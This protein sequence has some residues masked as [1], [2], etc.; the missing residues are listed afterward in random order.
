MAE[1]LVMIRGTAFAVAVLHGSRYVAFGEAEV[2]GVP[3]CFAVLFAEEPCWVRV[4]VE[5]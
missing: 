5:D 2:N 4:R 1:A 3:I